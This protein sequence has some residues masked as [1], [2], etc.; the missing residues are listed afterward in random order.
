SPLGGNRGR[1]HRRDPRGAGLSNRHLGRLAKHQNHP[2]PHHR[3]HPRGRRTVGVPDHQD[4]RIPLQTPPHPRLSSHGFHLLGGRCRLH[5]FRSLHAGVRTA[6]R[7]RDGHHP[8]EPKIGFGKTQS[9]VQGEPP[10]PHHFHP[11]PRPFRKH[12]HAR[13]RPRR[14]RR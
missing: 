12:R 7:H 10:T 9:G 3:H 6:H 2:F 4:H 8:G 1:S 13:S 5:R 14:P 11:L